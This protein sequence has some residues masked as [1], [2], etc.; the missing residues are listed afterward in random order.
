METAMRRTPLRVLVVDDDKE[1]Y[2]LLAALLESQ[3]YEVERA[4]HTLA[5]FKL[6]QRRHYE[7]FIIDARIPIILGT[8]LAEWLKEQIAASRI[9]LISAF[10][11]ES[12]RR[13]AEQLAVPLLIKPFTNESLLAL[14]RQSIGA[15]GHN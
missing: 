1:F 15:V 6:S 2:D 12:L 7:L 14:V 10:V 13:R 8:R 3:G 4:S 11:D 5:A 9:I